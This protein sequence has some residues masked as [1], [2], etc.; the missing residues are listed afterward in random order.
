VNLWLV[1]HDTGRESPVL[2]VS[3]DA[4]IP[5]IFYVATFGEDVKTGIW[6]Y[7]YYLSTGW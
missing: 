1:L 2:Q 6:I 5:V 7:Y 4:K 3:A